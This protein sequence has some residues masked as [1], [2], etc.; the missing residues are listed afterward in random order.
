MTDEDPT[1]ELEIIDEEGGKVRL[2]TALGDIIVAPDSGCRNNVFVIT[3]DFEM[4]R[5]YSEKL[6]E[7]LNE[8]EE[9]E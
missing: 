8:E 6:A 2:S 4:E 3:S 9:E 7:K 5:C 1:P